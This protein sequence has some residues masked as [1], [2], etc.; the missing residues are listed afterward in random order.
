MF[1]PAYLERDMA[2]AVV[3]RNEGEVPFSKPGNNIV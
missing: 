2:N 1:I 3:V